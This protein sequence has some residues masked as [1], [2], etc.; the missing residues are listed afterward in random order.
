MIFS[1][2]WWLLF[3]LL[4]PIVV[5]LHALTLRWRS[6]TTSSLVFWNEVLKERRA[7]LRIRR[8]LTN[9]LLILQLIAIALIGVALGGPT[10]IRPATSGSQDVILVLDATAG[11]QAKEGARTRWDIALERG[12][13]LASG[14]RG[15]ARM[16][17]VLAEKR[18]RLLASFTDDKSALRR[19]L[20]SARPTD[21]PGDVAASVLY[22]ISLRDPRR[23]G[24]VVLETDGAF[25]ELHGVDMSLPWITVDVVGTPQ[26]NVGI[27]HMSFRQASTAGA[28]YELFLAVMNAG[29]TAATVPLTVRADGKDIVSR[30]L[31]LGPGQ[32]STVTIPWTGPAAGRVVASVAAHD[33]LPL[34]DLAYA[35][36]APARRVSVLVVGQRP[37]FIQQALASLPG[38]TVKMQEVPSADEPHMD[39]VV[40]DDVQ[41][42]PLLQG[43]FI[44]FNS[45]PSGLPVRARGL[46]RVPAVT[47]WNRSD[48]LLDSVSLAD[49]TIGQALDLYPGP[50]FSIL[51]NSGTSPLVLRWDHSDLKALV[52]AFDPS[53]SDFPLRPGFPILLANA[54]SWFFPDWLQTQVDQTQAGDPR[55]IAT[56]GAPNLTVVKPDGRKVDMTA[57]GPSVTFFDTDEVGFYTVDA[58][59]ETSEFAVNLASESET[60][61]TPRFTSP[62]APEEGQQQRP[63]VPVPVWF[64]VG[65]AAL[66]LLVLEWIAWLWQPGRTRTA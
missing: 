4:L 10:V 36:F 57:D 21:E 30:T 23:G 44:L 31:S 50:G 53:S 55:V 19:L 42:P 2:P 14:L 65:I 37:A 35:R 63:G 3:L 45:V 49:V 6:V 1:S 38:V 5:V 62:N 15:G 32:R 48:P 51:A 29:R 64:V 22:A 11:M 47:G 66:A 12:V 18:P 27:T 58:G 8:L 17:V 16:A 56:R 41:P 59:G 60:N 34:D 24:R 20:R 46:L 28:G 54:I 40:Y 25:D 7:N 39:V 61:T 26:D 52:V 9:L 43:N 33:A 13:A